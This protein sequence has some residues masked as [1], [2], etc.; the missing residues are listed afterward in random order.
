MSTK[1]TF[2]NYIYDYADGLDEKITRRQYKLNLLNLL[3]KNGVRQITMAYD[4]EE[5][6]YNECVNLC[7]ERQKPSNWASD[8]FKSVYSTRLYE[9]CYALSPTCQDKTFIEGLKAQKYTVQEIIK[10]TT[11]ELCPQVSAEEIK[12]FEQ[13]K[14]SKIEE[15]TTNRYKCIMCGVKKCTYK[16]VTTGAADEITKFLIT[17]VTCGKQ[18]VS[19]G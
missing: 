8:Y 14:M 7:L 12:L 10:M 11:H 5:L 2:E 6:V 9:I 18:W 19:V 4:I 16:E 15:K 1:V 13:R 3:L 17:C